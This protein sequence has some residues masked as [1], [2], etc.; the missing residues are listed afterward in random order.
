MSDFMT[1]PITPQS[2]KKEITRIQNTQQSMKQKHKEI[3]S[4]Q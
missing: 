3:N 4:F 1:N 2:F